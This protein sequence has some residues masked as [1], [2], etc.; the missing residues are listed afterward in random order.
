MSDEIYMAIDCICKHKNGIRKQKKKHKQIKEK[1][2]KPPTHNKCK[3]LASLIKKND[4]EFGKV[5]NAE[6]A[7]RLINCYTYTRV[8]YAILY[9]S[10]AHF[11]DLVLKV[12]KVYLENN[13][14]P[15]KII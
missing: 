5:F 12:M 9:K 4:G 6:W 14:K 2:K 10:M 15:L 3:K 8:A 13:L 7:Q 1:K 11:L